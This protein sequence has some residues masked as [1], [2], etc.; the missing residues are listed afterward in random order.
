MLLAVV[1]PVRV[2]LFDVFCSSIY[3]NVLLSPYLCF[4]S[5][6]SLDLFVLGDNALVRGLSCKPTSLYLYP[7]L[8]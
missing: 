5:F 3:F 6:V 8:N 4:I 2:Y 1:R 7:H